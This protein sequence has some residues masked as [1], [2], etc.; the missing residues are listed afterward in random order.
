VSRFAA[1][2][3]GCVALTAL[4]GMAGLLAGTSDVAT[5]FGWLGEPAAASDTVLWQ[6]RA[7]RTLGAWCAG[8][9]LALA[10]VLAQG[11]F[12]NSLAD[13]YL[14]GSASGAALGVAL[15]LVGAG[16]S[17]GGLAWA[18]QLGITGA[19]FVGACAAILLTL[20]LAR[21]VAQTTHLLLA[22]VVVGFVL[23]AITSLLLI[24]SPEAW[25]AMQSF[26]LG[27]TGYL[28]WPATGLL[29]A[30]L[31]ACALPALLLARGLD[32]LTLGED[33]AR[34]LGLSVPVLRL[35]LLALVSLATAATVA[36]VGAVGFI[37]LVAP[38]LARQRL[39]GTHR[40]LLVAATLAGG[41]L[42]LAA[43]VLSRWL[44]RPAELPVGAVT[45]CLGGVYLIALLWRRSRDE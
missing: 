44:I 42:M 23:A 7:P 41:V 3:L 25:R 13:P 40:E 5:S 26:L 8:A 33:A 29:A 16:A 6:I 21:G 35:T 30:A 22:G 27:S 10:G 18:A 24:G 2:V 43:D 32:A 15:S 38:H 9:L 4:L 12:R 45:A 31:L 37:G 19:A 1:W 14:L 20:A 28:G 34:S 17:F 39:H 11:V 36:Q